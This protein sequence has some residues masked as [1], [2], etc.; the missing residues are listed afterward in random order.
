MPTPPPAVAPSERH[1]RLPPPL[2]RSPRFY[3]QPA[4]R[5]CATAAAAAGNRCHYHGRF[6]IRLYF[7]NA[8][9]TAPAEDPA[10]STQRVEARQEGELR[11]FDIGMTEGSV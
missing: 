1:Y 11:R 9:S 8:G 5:P 2:D 6:N 10:P 3:G 4:T 7:D